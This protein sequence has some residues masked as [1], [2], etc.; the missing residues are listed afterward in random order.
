MAWPLTPLAL[1]A[2]WRQLSW[3]ANFAGSQACCQHPRVQAERR[4]MGCGGE[5]MLDASLPTRR[6][7]VVAGWR[8]HSVNNQAGQDSRA[9]MGCIV[10][11]SGCAERLQQRRTT[12][13]GGACLLP[14][15]MA[16]TTL[17]SCPDERHQPSIVIMCHL[18]TLQEGWF[19]LA[20]WR[21]PPGYSSANTLSSSMRPL[22]EQASCRDQVRAYAHGR[23]RPG[24]AVPAICGHLWPGS[25]S[26]ARWRQLVV[27]GGDPELKADDSFLFGSIWKHEEISFSCSLFMPYTLIGVLI[28]YVPVHGGMEKV[29]RGQAPPK[30]EEEKKETTALTPPIGG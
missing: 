25:A 7:W 26:R 9:Q 3:P 21:R 19:L 13:K 20:S 1:R 28:T 23:A 15:I 16:H 4:G 18:A 12:P 11:T 24:C 2:S 14:G 6:C 5:G 22:Q 30:S 8:S 27:P 17:H 10:L 29:R